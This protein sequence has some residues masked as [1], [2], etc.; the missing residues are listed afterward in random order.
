MQQ[1]LGILKPDCLRRKLMG[2]V[3]ARLEETGFTLADGKIRQMTK[4]EAEGFYAVHKERPFFGELIEFMISGPVFIMK[5]EREN[6][7]EYLREVI[8]NT[9][10]ADAAP[11]TI[12]KEY[13]HV[14]LLHLWGGRVLAL[15]L[16][17][18]VV[19]RVVDPAQPFRYAWTSVGLAVPL[20]QE[21]A[22]R[23][24][25]RVVAVDGQVFIVE[26]VVYHKRNHFFREL[27]FAVVV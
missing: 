25:G 18:G 17:N 9:D 1:T 19:S 26:G 8:G 15:R 20:F 7:V 22:L 3:I 24:V 5:L 6:A 2:T 13:V 27:I 21:G 23:L 10:P 12:R 11:G 4:A 16:P 14:C